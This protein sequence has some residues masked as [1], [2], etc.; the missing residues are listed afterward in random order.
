MHR[1]LQRLADAG[2]VTVTREGNQKYYQSSTN[3]PVFAEL[4]G[5]IVKTVGIV[6]PLRAALDPIADQIHLAFVFGSVAKGRERADSDLDLLVVADDLAYTDVYSAL[7][8]AERALGRTIN[9]TVFTRRE[10]INKRAKHD[11]FAARIGSQP[12]LFVIGSDD[13]VE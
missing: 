9:P 6:D 13:A 12:R 8:T 2:L 7:A 1:Q 5:L 11:S 4:H 3:A 10:W